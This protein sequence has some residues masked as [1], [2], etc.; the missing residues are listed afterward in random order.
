MLVQIGFLH[1]T[2]T[3]QSRMCISHVI[4]IT[5]YFTFCFFIC[6]I[7]VILITVHGSINRLKMAVPTGL[8]CKNI[9]QSEK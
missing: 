3:L 2:Y 5:I 9:K 1:H 4:D 7:F 8:V 6:I